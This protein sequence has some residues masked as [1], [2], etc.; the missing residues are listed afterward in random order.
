MNQHEG[1][2]LPA[3]SKVAGNFDGCLHVN[4]A[5]MH[6]S[7]IIYFTHGKVYAVKVDG[8]RPRIADRLRSAGILTDAAY[9]EVLAK[10]DGDVRSADAGAAAVAAGHLT[11]ETLNAVHRELLLSALGAM[12]TW[13]TASASMK[14][15]EATH[16]FTIEPISVPHLLKAISLRQS[17]WSEMWDQLAPRITVTEARPN[18]GKAPERDQ[19]PQQAAVLSLADGTRTLDEIAGQCGLTRFETVHILVGFASSGGI[20]FHQSTVT[21]PAQVP[22]EDLPEVPPEPELVSEMTP[23]VTSDGT[24]VAPDAAEDPVGVGEQDPTVLPVG[25]AAP[26]PTLVPVLPGAPDVSDSTPTDVEELPGTDVVDEPNL[27]EEPVPA[28]DVRDRIMTSIHGYETQAASVAEHLARTQQHLKDNAL[29]LESATNHTSET[30]RNVEQLS[31]TL[32][33]AEAESQAAARRA[34]A[35][36]DQTARIQRTYA[37]AVERN[38]AAEGDLRRLTHRQD[39]TQATY[40]ALETQLQ[41]IHSAIAH[42]H[43]E[44]HTADQQH[45]N[46][47]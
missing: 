27:E 3:L 47:A 33:S 5:D 14:A 30:R 37:D 34:A 44:L 15:K 45:P 16:E 31:R 6:R 42:A 41:D 24:T 12:C 9:D 20:T 43:Q 10:V 35:A 23:P 1:P 29:D 21:V 25:N 8:Y 22:V 13:P 4:D 28:A 17:R 40:A 18:C 36:L 7:G 26:A 32:A 39:E 46:V 11:A 19:D 2:L 38:T